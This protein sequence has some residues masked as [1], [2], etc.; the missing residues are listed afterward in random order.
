MGVEE[1]DEKKI[2]LRH[3]G[4]PKIVSLPKGTTFTARYERISR[5]NLPSNIRLKK[6]TRKISPRNK[7]RRMIGSRNQRK[8]VTKKKIRFPPSTSLHERLNWIKRCRA[9]RCTQTGSGLASNLVIQMGSRAINSLLRKKLINKG[10]ENITNL[11]KYGNFE[12]KN[13]NH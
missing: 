2:V 8:R 13:S 3:R 5:K 7:R 6:K 1:D 12:I 10:I 9:S 11:I 4:T